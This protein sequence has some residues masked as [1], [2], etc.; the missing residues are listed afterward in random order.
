MLCTRPQGQ[1]NEAG[2]DYPVRRLPPLQ[3]SL[4]CTIDFDLYL[5]ITFLE[6]PPQRLA[7]MLQSDVHRHQIFNQLASLIKCWLVTC[8]SR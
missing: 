7:I 6:R 1:Y 4:G 8:V 5:K 2:K 3:R